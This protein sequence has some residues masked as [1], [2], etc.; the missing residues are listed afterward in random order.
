MEFTTF[1]IFFPFYMCIRAHNTSFHSFV[2]SG[3]FL[4][5]IGPLIVFV[6]YLKNLDEH[7]FFKMCSRIYI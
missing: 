3:L 6:F 5:D 1:V 4:S 2:T 7:E